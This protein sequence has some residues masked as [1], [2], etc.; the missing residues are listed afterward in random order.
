MFIKHE[1]FKKC[2][3]NERLERHPSI[4]EFGSQTDQVWYLSST[5][6]L[7]IS[8]RLFHLFKPVFSMGDNNTYLRELQ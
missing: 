7:L 8:D 2:L 5:T 3:Q 4:I 1:V 6:Y